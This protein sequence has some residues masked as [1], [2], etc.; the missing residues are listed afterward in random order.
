MQ[1]SRWGLSAVAEGWQ[2]LG[3]YLE[4][5][6]EPQERVHDAAL[7]LHGFVTM[8]TPILHLWCT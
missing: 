5:V 6:T 7:V 2:R 1:S 8:S 3:S 4:A